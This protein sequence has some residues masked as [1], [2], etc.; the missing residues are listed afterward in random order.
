MKDKVVLWIGPVWPQ[1]IAPAVPRDWTIY[2]FDDRVVGGSGSEAYKNWAT[3]LGAD[4]LSRIAPGAQ[5]IVVA[6]F[7]RAHGAINV[8]LGWAAANR[9]SRITSLIALDSYYSAPGVTVPKP[10]YLAWCQFALERNLPVIFTTSSHHRAVEQSASDSVR[11]LAH[12]LQ[13]QQTSMTMPNLPPPVK[14]FGRGGILWLDYQAKLSHE[15]HPLKLAQPILSTGAPF[16]VP[17]ASQAPRPPTQQAP[18]PQ[19]PQP[20]QQA[21]AP[22]PN[23]RAPQRTNVTNVEP[24]KP[25]P[26]GPGPSLA[27]ALLLL[28]GLSAAGYSLTRLRP[29]PKPKELPERAD[30]KPIEMNG[31]VI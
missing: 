16:R 10:G 26:K 21:F 19:A 23:A 4:P 12:A 6:G 7:S 5:Q 2:T 18:S 28:A 27:I 8:L 31:A 17:L 29:K 25:A 11:P 30:D 3:A 22:A 1:I 13:L 9:D 24:T 20:T 15:D 14:A